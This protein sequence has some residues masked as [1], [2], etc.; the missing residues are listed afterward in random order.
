LAP[1]R[2]HKAGDVPGSVETF[3]GAQPRINDHCSSLIQFDAFEKLRNW[4]HANT[5]DDHVGLDQFAV[6]EHD[7]FDVVS[8]LE[9]IDDATQFETNA[10]T[11]VLTPEHGADFRAES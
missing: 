11:L 4:T 7:R 5:N 9:S 6:V 1:S 2:V 3:S 8:A 10:V